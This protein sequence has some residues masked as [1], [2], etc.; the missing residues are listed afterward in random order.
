MSSWPFG[1]ERHNPNSLQDQKMSPNFRRR[2][3]R[4]FL[5]LAHLEHLFQNLLHFH[6]GMYESDPH[7]NNWSEISWW[8]WPDSKWTLEQFTCGEKA[9]QSISNKLSWITTGDKLHKM[10]QFNFVSEHITYRSWNPI[11]LKC[12]VIALLWNMCKKTIPIKPWFPC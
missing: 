9:I 3:W 7:K 5:H 2:V 12:C 8:S 10:R 4:A 11:I 6:L 1:I